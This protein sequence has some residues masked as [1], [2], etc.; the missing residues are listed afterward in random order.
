[1]LHRGLGQARK[2]KMRLGGSADLLEPFPAKPKGM[3][4]AHFS[5]CGPARKRQCT[6]LFARDSQESDRNCKYQ[7]VIGD[8]ASVQMPV[9]L[10]A[11]IDTDYAATERGTVLTMALN[12]TERPVEPLG[13]SWTLSPKPNDGV[14][15][16]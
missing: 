16:R 12:D 13:D 5:V 4:R 10:L 11:L 7:P 3:H 15:Q 8:T 2:I 6:A 14:Q 9:A 1:V